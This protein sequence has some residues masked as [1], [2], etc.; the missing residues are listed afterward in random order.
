MIDTRTFYNRISRAYDRIA[1]AS[2]RACRD[3]GVEVIDAKPGERVLELGFGTGHGLV[4]LADLMP[5]QGTLWL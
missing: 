2:E 4:A 5:A 1:D 3:R